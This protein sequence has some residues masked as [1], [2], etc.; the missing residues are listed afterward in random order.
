MK[1]VLFT[2][3]IALFAIS[4]QNQGSTESSKGDSTVNSSA[5]SKIEYAY[6]PPD[7]PADY[8]ERGNQKNLEFVL[9]SLKAFENNNID[10][11]ITAFADSVAVTI[12]GYDAK[13]TRDSLKTLFTRYRT[14]FPQMQIKM[15]DYES[16]ISKDKKNEWVSLW[17]KEINT[18]KSGMVDS[19]F[20]M[21]DLKIVDGKIAVLDEKI[22]HYP[23]KK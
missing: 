10:E 18:N 20:K 13:I 1:W 16:V 12:D 5:D 22:R 21:F 3:A 15:E 2:G 9:K 4:C 6:L 8:W 14:D 7:H 23:K 11:C 17:Y 19:I